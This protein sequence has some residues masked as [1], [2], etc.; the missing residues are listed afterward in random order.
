MEDIKK[1]KL[2]GELK[3]NESQILNGSNGA[4]R[5][6]PSGS[7]SGSGDDSGSGGGSGSGD[8]VVSDFNQYA[9]S[10]GS[11]SYDHYSWNIRTSFN[12]YAS[13]KLIKGEGAGESGSVDFNT[14]HISINNMFIIYDGIADNSITVGRHYS[15]FHEEVLV[16]NEQ[17]SGTTGS[18]GMFEEVSFDVLNK[19]LRGN[20]VEYTRNKNGGLTLSYGP[21]D[22]FPVVITVTLSISYNETTSKLSL[23]NV[24]VNT[25]CTK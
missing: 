21:I 17:L 23:E 4:K 5:L 10:C 18:A 15:A 20:Y 2:Q 6:P 16:L 3:E 13:A 19:Q 24:S 14:L 25:R 1:I 12:W 22:Y 11:Y 7:G 9:G 8:T